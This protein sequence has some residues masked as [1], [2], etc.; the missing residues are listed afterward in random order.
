MIAVAQLRSTPAA[1]LHLYSSAAGTMAIVPWIRTVF[2]W[3]Y[4]AVPSFGEF[5]NGGAGRY[6]VLDVVVGIPLAVHA[7]VEKIFKK[8]K[9]QAHWTCRSSPRTSSPLHP[10]QPHGPPLTSAIGPWFWG[11][12]NSSDVCWGFVSQVWRR[13]TLE[14]P[15]AVGVACI[16]SHLRPSRQESLPSLASAAPI[17]NKDSLTIT[18][19]KWPIPGTWRCGN[20]PCRAHPRHLPSH[21]LLSTQNIILKTWSSLE[22]RSVIWNILKR[23][24]PQAKI[25]TTLYVDSFLHPFVPA[26]IN[27]WSNYMNRFHYINYCQN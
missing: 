11:K 14:L 18:F 21:I 15:A 1:T 23:F 27:K 16:V 22:K 8:L 24:P 19:K 5:D 9:S 6:P 2:C 10:S 4:W 12:T 7:C 17:S 25:I 20:V 13:N 3:L 26:R